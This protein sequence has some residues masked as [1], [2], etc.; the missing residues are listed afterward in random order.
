MSIKNLLTY[1]FFPFIFI[2]GMAAVYWG[3]ELNYIPSVVLSLVTLISLV[4]I[5]IAERLNPYILNWNVPQNDVKTNAIH[6]FVTVMLMEVI[7]AAALTPML[8]HI[9]LIIG[10][11]TGLGLWPAEWPVAIQVALALITSQFGEYWGHR[12]MHEIPLFWRFHATH[13]SIGRLHWLSA[14]RVH[15]IDTIV[16]YVIS[17]TPLLILGVPDK[18]LIFFTTWV[19]LRGVLQ[20]CNVRMKL[21]PLNYII[22]MGEVHRWHHSVNLKESNS[23]YGNNIMF[24]DIVFGTFYYPQDRETGDHVGLHDMPDFPE[25]YIGQV[26]SP[27]IWNRI[28]KKK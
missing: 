27:F 21:G 8:L 28:K 12:A 20:H 17:L 1:A 18:T 3:M 11:N 10:E 6:L 15:P 13:H 23:N 7:F 2:S 24:W 14:A 19:A 26:L 16:M 25:D 9:A 5:I 4:L 22:S